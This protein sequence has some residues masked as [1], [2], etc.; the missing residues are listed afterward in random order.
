MGPVVRPMYDGP[1]SEAYV[2]WFTPYKILAPTM[3]EPNGRD[4]RTHFVGQIKVGIDKKYPDGKSKRM[5]E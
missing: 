3:D 4:G 2:G 5:P 1:C